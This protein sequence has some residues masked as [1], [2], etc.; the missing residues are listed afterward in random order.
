VLFR[1]L[2][3]MTFSMLETTFRALLRTLDPQACSRGTAP[4]DGVAKCLLK[5]HLD[6]PPDALALVD[7]LR[8]VR[9]TVHNNGIYFHRD[10]QDKAV[11]FRGVT[12]NFQIG[13]SV[14][15]VGGPF[16]V[17]RLD[18]V[19]E[20]LWAVVTHPNVIGIPTIPDPSA[21]A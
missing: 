8:E 4:F 11:Q 17:E 10:W 3:Q 19:R 1:S 20:L 13:K 2:I 21:S 16:L 14:D 12:Y 7:L 5:T 18:D 9:N 15:F 6:Q